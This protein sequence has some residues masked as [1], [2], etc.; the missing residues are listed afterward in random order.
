MA[1]VCVRAWEALEAACIAKAAIIEAQ[2][3]ELRTMIVEL[4]YLTTLTEE[5]G[6]VVV[7]ERERTAW[8]PT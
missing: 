4:D 5:A 8:R 7:V 3:A 6:R 2:Q 1:D